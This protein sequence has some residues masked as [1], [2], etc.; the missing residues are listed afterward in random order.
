MPNL[1]HSSEPRPTEA[2][3]GNGCLGWGL[4]GPSVVL[5]HVR[6]SS[7]V[8]LRSMHCQSRLWGIVVRLLSCMGLGGSLFPSKCQGELVQRRL[9]DLIARP[10]MSDE[11]LLEVLRPCGRTTTSRGIM[12]STLQSRR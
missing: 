9:N 8:V 3:I 4:G 10:N 7:T 1:D 11:V 12:C 5:G 2:H 6:P